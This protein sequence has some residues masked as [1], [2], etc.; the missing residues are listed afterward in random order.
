VHKKT[1]GSP[2]NFLSH[3]FLDEIPRI[4]A[5]LIINMKIIAT[6]L[7]NVKPQESSAGIKSQ[8]NLSS[9]YDLNNKISALSLCFC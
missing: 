2:N 8:T 5:G 1:G 7:N 9:N 3:I 4:Q 6:L